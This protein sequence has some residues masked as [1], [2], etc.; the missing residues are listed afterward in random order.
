MP[1]LAL[2][3]VQALLQIVEWNAQ[4]DISVFRVTSDLFP[5]KY[6]KDS[7]ASILNSPVQSQ[8]LP[9]QFYFL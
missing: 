3:N 6:K 5:W 8:M 2:Q 4:H 9:S 1:Q 7:L